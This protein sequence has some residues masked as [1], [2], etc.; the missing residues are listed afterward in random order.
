MADMRAD[1]SHEPQG[2]DRARVLAVLATLGALWCLF[3]A[4]IQSAVWNAAETGPPPIAVTLMAAVIDVGGRIDRV[5]GPALGL[6]PYEFWGRLFVLVYLGAIAGVLVIRQTGPRGR[7]ARTGSGL[8]LAGLLVALVGD[9]AAYWAHGT[10]LEDPL[11][12]SGFAVELTGLLLVLIGTLLLGAALLRARSSAAGVLLLCGSVLAVPM[13]FVVHY[14]PH[15]TV[16]PI[17]LAIAGASWLLIRE[18]GA[19]VVVPAEVDVA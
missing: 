15:G 3:L 12:S 4:P 17:A 11:W 2:I 14:I 8:L 6:T 13:T 18:A 16:L 5:V 1:S 10:A 9:V 7:L 19:P